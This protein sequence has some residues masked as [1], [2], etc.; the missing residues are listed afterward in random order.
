MRLRRKSGPEIVPMPSVHGGLWPFEIII[1][2]LDTGKK[3]GYRFTCGLFL[4]RAV[5]DKEIDMAFRFVERLIERE[6]A[7]NAG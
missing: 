6:N 1:E 4:T 3:Y 5:A 7:L 2:D